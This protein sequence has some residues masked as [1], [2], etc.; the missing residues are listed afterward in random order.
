MGVRIED[1]LLAEGAQK[2]K[3]RERASQSQME[4]I[5]EKSRTIESRVMNFRKQ[6]V[7][8]SFKDYLTARSSKK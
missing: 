3:R 4:E 8:K 6:N 2:K 7:K 1:R 5:K